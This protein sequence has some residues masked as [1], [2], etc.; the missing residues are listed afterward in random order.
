M[1]EIKRRSSLWVKEQFDK[2]PLFDGWSREYYA[3]TLAEKD[4]AAVIEYINTQQEH[5]H[6]TEDFEEE[7]KRF[8]EDAGLTWYPDMVED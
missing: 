3:A 6:G 8:V 2:Y 4:S 1:A 5:H 7:L